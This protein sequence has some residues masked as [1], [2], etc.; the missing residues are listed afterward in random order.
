MKIFRKTHFWK[1]NRT[2]IEI[3]AEEPRIERG[4]PV[5][6]SFLLKIGE[7][8]SIKSAFKLNPD[9]ARALRD[10][11]EN[12]LHIH[13]RKYSELMSTDH[14]K[15]EYPPYSGEYSSEPFEKKEYNKDEYEFK[16]EYGKD[17]F[18][19]KPEYTKMP[20]EK[21]PND[22]GFMIFGNDEAPAPKKED[23][24]PNVEFYF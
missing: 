18:S 3:E 11:I 14:E 5:E 13:D 15:K 9:E 19:R 24:K 2:F 17:D 4:Y 8:S 20:A 22:S 1:D 23:K 6:G 7:Q 21:K 12:Y 10:A 16:P